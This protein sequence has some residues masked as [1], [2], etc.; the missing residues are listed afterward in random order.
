MSTGTVLVLL[1]EPTGARAAL[2]AAVAAAPALGSP[3]IEV[4]HVRL[5]PVRTILPSEE[6]LTP[7]RINAVE[8]AS[9]I[10]GAATYDAYHAWQAAGHQGHWIEVIGEPA[11]EVAQRGKGAGLVVLTLPRL[12]APLTDRAALEAAVFATGCPVLAVPADWH[13]GFGAHVAVGWH[14]TPATRHALTALRPWLLAAKAVTALTVGEASPADGPLVGL[15]GRLDQQTVAPG[16]HG[17]GAALLSA[18]VATGADMLAM[19]A[20][21]RGRILEWALG[22][23]TEYALHHATLPLLLMH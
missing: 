22:G 10:E 4:V 17:D 5:D 2:D 9:A 19:G 16:D 21:R 3:T 14:D 1:T 13:G 8:A 7:A 20:Y 18:A 15:P 23:V 6:V 11:H 12:H